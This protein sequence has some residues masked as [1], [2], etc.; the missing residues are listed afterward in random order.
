MQKITQ[1]FKNKLKALKNKLSS[2]TIEYKTTTRDSSHINIIFILPNTGKPSG[3]VIVGH[4]HSDRINELAFD[5]I[6]SEVVYP[7]SLDYSPN[8]FVHHSKIKR[9]LTFDVKKDF[10]I[11]AEA[12][13]LRFAP[14]LVEANIKFG[15]HVQNGYLMDLEVQSGIADYHQ[16]K[17]LY[18]KASIII[19]NSED[20]VANIKYAFP[21]CVNKTIQSSF[22]INKSKYQ[23]IDRKSNVITYMPRKLAKHSKLLLFFLGDKLPKHWS[24]RAIDGVTEQEVYDI[25]YDS[26]IFL[27][28]SEF[29]GLAMPPAMAAMSGNRV[30]GYTGEAN[31]EYFHLPCFEEVHSGDI[32]LFVDKLL[33]AVERFDKNEE[34]LDLNSIKYLEEMF[35]MNRQEKFLAELVSAVKSHLP[36]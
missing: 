4:H 25:F 13:V 31:K 20:T 16:L 18:S 35:S 26:K 7:T 15:I 27:S 36:S 30:I 22:V 10:V 9:D 6:Q 3:G 1:I 14:Q 24:I 19:G 21:D 2:E 29:E 8:L 33:K 34:K 17:A 23:E 11:V 28:F 32:K 12:M 5:G